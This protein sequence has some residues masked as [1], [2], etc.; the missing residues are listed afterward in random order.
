MATTW[1][2]DRNEGEAIG[3]RGPGIGEGLQVERGV[4]FFAR[5]PD[6]YAHMYVWVYV[7]VC[8]YMCICVG[9]CMRVY[10]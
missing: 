4:G 8:I 7:Y 5:V 2:E 1:D 10:V 6:M 3:M 9:N